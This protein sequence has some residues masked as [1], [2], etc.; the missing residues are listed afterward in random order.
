[1]SCSLKE[2]VV[3]HII[4][5][6]VDCNYNINSISVDKSLLYKLKPFGLISIL[7]G[8][9]DTVDNISLISINHIENIETDLS[10][11]QLI[12]IN[13]VIYEIINTHNIRVPLLHLKEFSR[14]LYKHSLRTAIYAAAIGKALELTKYDLTE[15]VTSALL[16]DLGKEFIPKRIL[17]KDGELSEAD[18]RLLE[19]SP[20]LSS[21]TAMHL[22]FDKLVINTIA[23][24]QEKVDGSGYPLK[25]SSMSM[26]LFAKIISIVDRY[27]TI[28]NSK[29]IEAACTILMRESYLYDKELLELF[30]NSLQSANNKKL[31]ILEK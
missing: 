28:R 21:L 20:L 30:I 6:R 7:G 16:H 14:D 8:N 22:G 11:Y 12:D 18:N 27:D 25:L 3:V 9:I 17:K 2:D 15:L 19:V 26:T 13:Q 5:D 10:P 24:H 23:Q 31:D 1:M 29:P 4:R